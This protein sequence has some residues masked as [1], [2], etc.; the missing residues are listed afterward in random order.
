MDKK[1]KTKWIK[2]LRGRRYKQ[3]CGTLHRNVGGK[4]FYCCF[5]VLMKVDGRDCGRDST[6]SNGALSEWNITENQRITLERMNDGVETRRH[7]FAEIADYIEA[8]L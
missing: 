8:N 1:L 7:S 4:H 5:G 3:T 6:P 2:A